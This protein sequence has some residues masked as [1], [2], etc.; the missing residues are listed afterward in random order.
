MVN[1]KEKKNIMFQKYKYIIFLF[2]INISVLLSSCNPDQGIEPTIANS[3]EDA[4]KY[5]ST[6][7]QSLKNKN[8][9]KQ[10]VTYKDEPKFTEQWYLYN[11]T[12]KGLDINIVPAWQQGFG[13]K[14]IAIAVIDTGIDTMHPDLTDMILL[15][16]FGRYDPKESHGSNVAGLIAARDNHMGMIGVAP[17][18]KLYNYSIVAKDDENRL[19]YI[20]KALNHTKHKEIAVYNASIGN[21]STIVQLDYV[22]LNSQDKAAM[23]TV[24]KYGFS[25]KGSNI[26]FAAGNTL[27]TA[28]NDGYLNHHAV[29]NVNAIQKDGAIPKT[30]NSYGHT[31]GLNLW[32]TA[33]IGDVTSNNRG[34]YTDDFDHTSSAAPLVTGAIGLL[35]SEFPTLTW[36]DVKLI[37]AESASK[38]DHAS[39]AQYRKSGVLYSNKAVAQKYSTVMGF[40]LLD[41]NQAFMLAQ[42]WKLLPPMKEQTDSDTSIHMG[43]A[44]EYSHR[45]TVN[46]AIQFIESLTLE[47]IFDD[48]EQDTWIIGITSPD[49]KKSQITVLF[50]GS[51][52]GAII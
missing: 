10:L 52:N 12:I 27:T 19:D 21:I 40:G 11:T 29:I 37:L 14:P 44:R 32:L 5:H 7:S 16:C 33:P 15:P 34:G 9:N 42:N 1:Y 24:S 48:K 8:G 51:N 43:D 3:I 49:G 25:G 35:R 20:A 45:F 36:R 41:V 46:N 30:T 6:E 22:P 28:R 4:C 31:M 17:N 50:Y 18:A 38:Y 26:V 2:L 39:K 47:I 23:D 13:T